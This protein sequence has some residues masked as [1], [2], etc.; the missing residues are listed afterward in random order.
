MTVTPDGEWP[1]P[2]G[3]LAITLPL[4]ASVE[5]VTWLGRGPGEA[6]PDTGHATRFGRWES[7]VDGL[8][9]P[10]VRPQENGRRA[11][12]RWASFADADG[13]GLSVAGDFAFTARRWTDADLAAATHRNELTA[14][15]AVWLTIDVG[16]QGIGT[17][18]CGPG[19]LPE[20]ELT[21]R[22]TAFTVVCT[23][24]S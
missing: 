22:A 24:L 23:P 9:T 18:S 20:Y 1:E 8:Q 7:T 2:I 19:A 6:Y 12:V 15:D 4:P 21:L 10:Y 17:A 5:Q 14:G 11:D 16:Q 13:R 3:K